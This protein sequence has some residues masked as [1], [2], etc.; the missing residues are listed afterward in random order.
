MSASAILLAAGLLT[1]V[2]ALSYWNNSA[3]IETNDSRVQIRTLLLEFEKLITTLDDAETGQRGYLLV[4][5]DSYLKSFQVAIKSAVQQ[6]DRVDRLM[7]AQPGQR[8][9]FD[10]LQH[11]VALNFTELKET[12]QLRE[13]DGFEAAMQVVRSGEGQRMMNEIRSLGDEIQ[14]DI[15]EHLAEYDRK[16]ASLSAGAIYWSIL[17]NMLAV[18]LIAWVVRRERRERRLVE[19]QARILAS[20]VETL[21]TQ[22]LI[23]TEEEIEA[24]GQQARE[25][26]DF[27]QA[28]QDRTLLESDK[29][30]ETLG[31]QARELAVAVE[32]S[33]VLTLNLSDR[34]IE[35]LGQ[36]AR[37]L[38]T[39]VESSRILT[40]NQSDRKIEALGLEARKLATSMETSRILTLNLSDRKIEALGQ[41]ARKLATSTETSRIQTLILSD[42]KIEALGQE[43]RKLATSVEALRKKALNQSDQKIEAL[44][45]VARELANSVETSRIETL[46]LSNQEIRKLN[47]GLEQRVV[48]R[49]AQLEAANKELDSF[50]YSVSHDLRAPL[51][52]I[53]GFSRI[54]LEDCC[55]N[56][57]PEGKAYLNL[58]RDNTQQMGQLVDGLLAFSRL[59]RQPLT[60]QIVGP[61][62][63]VHR[64]LAEM[65][66][67]QHDRKVE[68]A[69]GD[70][71]DCNADPV[72]LKQVW[73]NLISNALKYTRQR[74][75]ARVEIGCRTAPRSV[76][77]GEAS[78]PASTDP[79]VIYFVKDNGAGF[80]MKYV[81]KLFGVFQRLHR[82]ADYEGT[83]VGLAIVQRI[84]QRH[85]GRIW[86]E[87]TPDQG[88]TFFFTLA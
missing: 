72:L 81:R 19:D 57:A 4:D 50:C 7:I 26:A 45:Q 30:I 17:G 75:I 77:I 25:L 38:A 71:P 31:Q 44:G 35:A 55:V 40:L 10:A 59:G 86:A 29:E 65:A 66:E 47:E 58:V 6:I 21:R 67:E 16:A 49:T 83:G 12:V 11:L 64:C 23:Q 46:N 62:A 39:S 70:L 20:S 60:K 69:V 18:V 37:A 5:E 3:L 28:V 2:G 68:I 80:D 84:V 22:T 36:E 52:A 33:R 87:A 88:A 24:L 53:D 48:E 42:Q 73:T 43:A 78:S 54:V 76:T 14:Q 41:E 1:A 61:E 85:G 56:L 82:A 13:R 15:Q 27:V 63:I 8:S 32:K 79:E 74:E 34:K 9:N 51:R